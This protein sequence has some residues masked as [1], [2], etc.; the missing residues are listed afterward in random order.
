MQKIFL[1]VNFAQINTSGEITYGC[2]QA[3]TVVTAPAL[4]REPELR[5][6]MLLMLCDVPID[7]GGA[8]KSCKS[9]EL[10]ELSPSIES[11]LE[12]QLKSSEFQLEDAEELDFRDT[13]EPHLELE[14]CDIL[15]VASAPRELTEG[16]DTEEDTASMYAASSAPAP[17]VDM[18]DREASAGPPPP[19]PSVDMEEDRAA[20]AGPPP[21]AP[22]VDMEDRDETSSP[23][24]VERDGRVPTV[25]ME[26][27]ECMLPSRFD[28][29]VLLS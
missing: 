20:S 13:M 19:A 10:R 7:E 8:G 22:S 14:L 4:C 28:T 12:L 29:L 5:L 26:D 9:M 18:E 16:D 23:L 2:N 27:N 15:D 17:S 11:V 21:P 6:S 3:E 24:S 25:D 1:F